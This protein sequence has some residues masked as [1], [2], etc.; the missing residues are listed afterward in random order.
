MEFSMPS[1][2]YVFGSLLVG[3]LLS[4]YLPMNSLVSRYLGSAITANIT[5]FFMALVTSVLLF[6]LWGEY[7]TLSRLGSVPRYLYL[8]GF[9]SAFIVLAT[10]FLIPKIG[11]R[12]FFIL[13]ISGQILTAMIV[14]HFGLLQTPQDPIALKKIIG[15]LL[16]IGGAVI[17]TL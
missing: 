2:G 13:T 4:I 3:G 12:K 11:V 10:T 17:S 9:V 7:A 1:N 6:G 15:A 5:F 14:S 8:T 16:V